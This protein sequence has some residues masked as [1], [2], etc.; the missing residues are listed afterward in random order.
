MDNLSKN[1]I[2]IGLTFIIF[3][4]LWYFIPFTQIFSKINLFKYIFN[5]PLPGNLPGDIKITTKHFKIY[6]PIM[7]SILLSILFTLLLYFFRK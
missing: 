6:F 5:L 2:I 1:L 3:G 4:I 7:T